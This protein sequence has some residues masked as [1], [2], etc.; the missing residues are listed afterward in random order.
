MRYN[1]VETIQY[2][3][4]AALLVTTFLL[5]AVMGAT[6]DS[7]SITFNPSG[8]IDLDISPQ[9]ADVGVVGAGSSAGTAANYFTL[10]NNGTVGMD[11]Q[12]EANSTTDSGNLTLDGDGSPG[13]DYFS[14][15]VTGNCPNQYISS[16]PANWKQDLAPG[17]SETF[18]ITVYL[19]QISMDY[20]QEKVTINV[21]GSIST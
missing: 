20:G 7:I 10:Y 2:V 19:G 4:V 17:G 13:L 8:N 14:L 6:S 11:T 21:T 15:Y 3:I 5:P 1:I 16:T 12:I 18:G 9:S